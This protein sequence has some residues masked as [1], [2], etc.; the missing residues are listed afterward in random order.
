MPID[1]GAAESRSD[2]TVYAPIHGNSLPTTKGTPKPAS[3]TSTLSDPTRTCLLMIR[4]YGAPPRWFA[5]GSKT[6]PG[7][8]NGDA[9]G[10]RGPEPGFLFPLPLASCSSA[11]SGLVLISDMHTGRAT[12]WRD[13]CRR[14][15]TRSRPR[16]RPTSS[17]ALSEEQSWQ[18]ISHTAFL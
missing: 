16:I 18:K 12:T 4:R 7:G 11:L 15:F 13:R 14:A 8:S 3:P 9:L 5:E 2:E 10:C 6:A 1:V 17:I